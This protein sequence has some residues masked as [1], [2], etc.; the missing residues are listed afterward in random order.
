MKK[1]LLALAA[2]GALAGTAQAQS[3]VSVYGIMDIGVIQSTDAVAATSGVQTTTKQLNT[4]Y[5]KGG[6]ASSRLG[7]RGTEDV[8]GGMSVGFVLE[9]GL[10]DIGIGGTGGQQ[11]SGTS[12]DASTSTANASGMIDP[13]Q[14][15][16]S[17]A[18]KNLGQIRLGRQAQS[19]HA[20][21]VDGSVGGGNNVAGAIYSGGENGGMNSASIRPELVWINRAV[22]YIS[23][24]FNGVTFEAQN[25]TQSI[26]S[27][28]TAAVPSSAATDTGASLRYAAGPVKLGVGY[29]VVQLNAGPT[30]GYNK[31][32]FMAASG[33]Y[34]FKVV[35]V[36]ALYTSAKKENG[37][38]ANLG[39]I[40]ATE[41]GLKAPVAKNI[42][43]WASGF[44]G[45]RSS[46]ATT[47]TI[48]TNSFTTY[49]AMS[50]ADVKGYQ[51]GAQYILSK[52]SSLYAIGGAQ[53]I[54]GRNVSNGINNKSSAAIVGINHTF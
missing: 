28:T 16:V 18:D 38:G 6:L 41:I 4:G 52:R 35:Q 31:L 33:S 5:G 50:E 36:F 39:N 40:G 13:R 43:V 48:A 7:F 53:A 45:T 47:A 9:Y 19:I 25:G 26:S 29:S 24:N 44:K 51:F 2:M 32:Q 20:V 21:I 49:T 17:L 34:D 8:G 46:N 12:A 37:A 15:Y 14:S 22:T 42:S 1:S 54:D 30:T 23:P 10:K 3:S 27:G 11:A